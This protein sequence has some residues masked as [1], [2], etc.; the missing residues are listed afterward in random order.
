MSRDF[1]RYQREWFSE[2]QRRVRSEGTPLALVNADAPHE[3]FRAMDIPYVVNQWWASVCAAKQRSADYLGYLR[4]R[5]YPDDQEP[6]SALALGS[7]FEADQDDAP[8]GGLPTPDVV[9]AHLSGDATGKIFELWAREYG[10]AF[11]PFELSIGPAEVEPRW[12]DRMHHE[13]ERLIEPQRLDLMV[14]ELKGLIRF[15]E[16]RTGRVFDEVKFARAMDLANEQATYNRATRDLIARTSPAPVSVADAIP[17]VMIPQWHRGSEWGRDAAKRFYEEVRSRAEAGEPA[18]PDER[19]RL[20]WIGR[21]LWFDMGFYQYFEQR[22]GAVFVWSMYLAVGA[23]CYLRYGDDPLRALAGRFAALSEQY[24]MPP[25][26]SEWYCKEALHNQIDGV[27]HLTTD[28]LRGTHFITRRLEEAG[29]PVVEITG[30]NV[31]SR[32]W[33]GDAVT[34]EIARFIERR[35]EPRARLRRRGPA[36]ADRGSRRTPRRPRR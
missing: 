4:D 14:E 18:L 17:S 20:M 25:W 23:D 12:F 15:L 10:A 33:D 21:G 22:Y 30:D 3:L 35:A 19:V 7:S 28:A 9:V 26:S 16:L 29:V 6:Y 31:D 36:A 8:W 27:V 1:V 32:R 11:Y 5:G 34:S 24:N 13:W 2:V